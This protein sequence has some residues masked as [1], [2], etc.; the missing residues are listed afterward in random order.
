[1]IRYDA[2]EAAAFREELLK[3][4]KTDVSACYQCG[5]CSAGCPAAFTF[6]Y[7]PNQVMRMLQVGMVEQVVASRSVQMCVQCLT[8]TARCPRNVDIAGIFEDLKT[9]AALKGLDA[10]ENAA[11]FNR[12]FL[13]NIAR[14]GRLSE[15]AFLLR[16][17]VA[18][19]RPFNDADL[20]R[21]MLSKRKIEPLPKKVEGSDEVGRIYSK[22]LEKARWRG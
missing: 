2:Q 7:A 12:T 6:D 8:C 1:L 18:I 20:G 21:P 14:Y 3:R 16:F 17:N 10:S 13:E 15:A 22:S 4:V 11:T 19:R 9:I 5:N